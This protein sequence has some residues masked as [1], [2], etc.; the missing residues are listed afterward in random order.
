MLVVG[1]K[2]CVSP[3]LQG[4]TFFIYSQ[5]EFRLFLYFRISCGNQFLLTVSGSCEIMNALC[6]CILI[7]RS[8]VVDIC[9]DVCSS[10][11]EHAK[12]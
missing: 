4:V 3:P 6:L 8:V 10:H 5:S 12:S 1:V 9:F 2:K 7:N 11:A